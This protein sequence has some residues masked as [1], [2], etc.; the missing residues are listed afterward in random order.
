MPKKWLRLSRLN[1]TPYSNVPQQVLMDFQVTCTK[2]NV[3]ENVPEKPR[4]FF[5]SR[6]IVYSNCQSPESTDIVLDRPQGSCTALITWT[7]QAHYVHLQPKMCKMDVLFTRLRRL[8][9]Q[10]NS[11]YLLIF[12]DYTFQNAIRSEVRWKK[13]RIYRTWETERNCEWSR[14]ALL[15]KL[16]FINA[17]MSRNSFSASWCHTAYMDLS[18]AFNL[19]AE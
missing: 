17:R 19:T 14:W 5:F 10:L 12:H 15:L 1:Q 11:Q 3:D 2:I 7:K 16:H 8:A 18:F 4:W 13:P 6:K 9:L